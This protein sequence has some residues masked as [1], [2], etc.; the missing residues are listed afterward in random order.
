MTIEKQ[1]R[2]RVS[3]SHPPFQAILVGYYPDSKFAAKNG[4]VATDLQ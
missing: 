3:K 4:S 2:E 1:R